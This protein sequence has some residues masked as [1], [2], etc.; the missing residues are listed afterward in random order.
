MKNKTLPLKV[1][2]VL[3]SIFQ[4]Y[5]IVTRWGED[6]LG[7]IIAS[8]ILVGCMLLLMVDMFFTSTNHNNHSK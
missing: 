6:A 5:T 1:G 7:T 3:L 2:I 8:V 4:V